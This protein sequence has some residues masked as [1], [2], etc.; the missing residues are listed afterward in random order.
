MSPAFYFWH[1]S[2]TPASS[3]S[4]HIL[5][6]LYLDG[7]ALLGTPHAQFA[8]PTVPLLPGTH[9]NSSCKLLKR[10]R[11]RNGSLVNSQ[12]Y[13]PVLL[14]GAK[15]KATCIRLSRQLR[16]PFTWAW[17]SAVYRGATVSSSFHLPT[18]PLLQGKR[19]SGSSFHAIK[20]M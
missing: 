8:D 12:S 15:I 2:S 1:V 19:G 6:G 18:G 14:Q 16:Q 20:V 4:L 5:L 3:P 9:P 11:L 17:H 13:N 10:G 7:A